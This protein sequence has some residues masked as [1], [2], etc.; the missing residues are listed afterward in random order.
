VAI[1]VAPGPDREKRERV[2]DVVVAIVLAILVGVF[3]YSL[4]DAYLF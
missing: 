2:A 4:I 1:A 3:I